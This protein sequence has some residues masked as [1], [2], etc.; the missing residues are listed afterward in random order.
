M[1]SLTT[2]IESVAKH[3]NCKGYILSPNPNENFVIEVSNDPLHAFEVYITKYDR[4]FWNGKSVN[5]DAELLD[6]ELVASGYDKN[7]MYSILS[8][9]IDYSLMN[10]SK[11]LLLTYSK[12]HTPNTILANELIESSIDALDMSDYEL[13]NLLMQSY[14]NR[15]NTYWENMV[16]YDSE[17]YQHYMQNKPINIPYVK[18][19]SKPTFQSVNDDL[20][21][22][23]DLVDY[24]VD[25]IVAID[26]IIEKMEHA[27]SIEEAT[28]YL[29]ELDTYCGGENKIVSNYDNGKVRTIS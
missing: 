12:T 27:N 1:N 23:N 26:S 11:Q 18:S 24:T 28:F 14:D 10:D 7:I 20:I 22:L 16:G 19:V 6:I 21:F 13:V 25:K 5:T 3:G 17:K 9:L 15:I 29:S 8:F 2:F 4:E